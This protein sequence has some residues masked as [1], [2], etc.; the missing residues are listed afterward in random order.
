MPSQLSLLNY[1]HLYYFRTIVRAGGVTAAAKTLGLTQSTLSSQLKSLEE[2]LGAKLFSREQRKLK[3]TASGVVAL[4]Y[5][6][7]I[8][9]NGEELSSW[10]SKGG[11]AIPRRIAI[12]ALSPISKNL[13]YE[14]IQPIIM[15]GQCDVHIMEGEQP[16]LLDRMRKHQVDLILTN[17][18][19]SGA[20]A[21]D[22]QTHLLGELPV[23]LVGRPPFKLSTGDFPEWLR[24]VPL[25]LP[26]SRT[27]ARIGFDALLAQS[28]I[29]PDI[30][31]EVD[32]PNLLRLLALSGGGLSLVP[33]IGV[34]FELEAQRLMKIEKVPDLTERYYAITKRSRRISPLLLQLITR[35]KE[36]LSKKVM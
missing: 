6:E 32:D 33:E 19:L 7:E 30:R 2:C 8:F 10:F 4:E 3:L 27:T 25:F 24:D 35:G 15:D 5:A 31:A 21:K 26:S 20:D 18:P 17:L 29:V 22:M 23:Y 13:Q 36:T 9:R 16:E 11:E 1:H 28:E 34:K 14:M 12:G